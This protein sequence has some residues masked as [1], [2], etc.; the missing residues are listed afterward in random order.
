MQGQSTISIKKVW[1]AEDDD[2]LRQNYRTLS[3]SAI[4]KILNV[5]R[6]AVIGRANRIGLGRAVEELH[7]EFRIKA[8]I[9]S[10]AEEEKRQ[11]RKRRLIDTGKTSKERGNNKVRSAFYRSLREGYSREEA[12]NINIKP[13][14]GVGVKMWELESNHCRWVIGEPK[15]MT[16][17][18]HA[19]H[20]GS[21]YC[22]EHYSISVV[23][24]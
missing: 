3:G 2:F 22:P 4:G 23:K 18:G 5:S 19:K 16:F 20:K 10:R 15:E 7:K 11:L 1:T 14:N 6:M 21:N 24:K 8:A 12:V 17:C 9:R 13:L